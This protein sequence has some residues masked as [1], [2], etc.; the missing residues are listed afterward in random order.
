MFFDIFDEVYEPAED[1]FLFAE[2]LYVEKGEDVLDLG[3]GCGILG[4]LAARDAN[5]VLAVDLN[6]YAIKCAKQNCMLNYSNNKIAFIQTDLFSA[7]SDSAAFDLVL[8]NA[9]YLPSEENEDMSWIGK[10][11]AGGLNGRQV[12][13]RFITQVPLHL[14]TEG[15]V[16]L[17]QSTLTGVE[18]TLKKFGEQH[19]LATIKAEI[20]TPFFETLTLIEAKRISL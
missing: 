10:A 19:L 4:V 11:W 12:V 2:N 9:P 6:P 16:L 18:E 8:F 20:K 5:F 17:M 7:F 14:K 1:T 3:T 15:R 13:D